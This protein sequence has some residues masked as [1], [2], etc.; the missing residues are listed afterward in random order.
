MKYFIIAILF[1]ITT[2]TIAEDYDYTLPIDSA[3]YRLYHDMD[4]EHNGAKLRMY[5][6]KDL[7][8]SKLKIAFERGRQGQGIEAGTFFLDQ[9]FKF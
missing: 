4:N 8:H 9:S 1:F 5:I 3:G 2:S 7:Y 6:G